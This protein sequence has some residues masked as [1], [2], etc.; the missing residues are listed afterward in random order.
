MRSIAISGC[1]ALVAI[2]SVVAAGP[3]AVAKATAKAG[4]AKVSVAENPLS[5]VSC[6]SARYCVAVGQ[7]S[8]ADKGN[9]APIAETWNGARWTRAALPQP[10]GSAGGSLE[11][12]ACLRVTDCA[13]AG[14]Y[15]RPDFSQAP[16]AG[17]WNGARWTTATATVPAG[18]TGARLDAIACPGAK[19]CI[20][21]GSFYLASGN[22][23]TLAEFW[24][25]KRWTAVKPPM[26]A[27]SLGGGL[28]GIACTSA[29]DCVAAG[30]YNLELGSSALPLIESW[31]GKK[32]TMTQAPAPTK[33][34]PT[35]LGGVSCPSAGF[36]MVA[37]GYTRADGASAALVESWNG[38]KW[39]DV[40]LPQHGTR[41]Q[42]TSVACA[43]AKSCV[44][45][46][47]Y[48]GGVSYPGTPSSDVWNGKAWRLAGVPAP[49][50]TGMSTLTGVRCLTADD[51]VAVG[52]AGPNPFAP[53]YGFS[54]FWNGKSWKLVAIA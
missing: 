4:S 45:A 18:S 34:S 47:Q 8:A 2:A 1:V 54:A 31:N 37:G 17:F 36:C 29:T 15:F 30:W 11:G 12:I 19:D 52:S 27:H 50:G 28:D 6:V 53:A 16:L 40:L 46:G 21:T 7:N 22:Y 26:P 23:G 49:A 35:I 25:G 9:G 38:R 10:T 32:W 48:G 3:A 43:T 42:M 14:W 20:A 51:C 13:A 33:T 41:G 44:T 24:S 39:S 5:G